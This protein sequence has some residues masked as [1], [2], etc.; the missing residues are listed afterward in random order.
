MFRHRKPKPVSAAPAWID[1]ELGP[2]TR[3]V[4]AKY[5]ARLDM[6]ELPP[7]EFWDVFTNGRGTFHVE[8]IGHWADGPRVIAVKTAMMAELSP[9]TIVAMAQSIMNLTGGKR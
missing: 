9:Q 5:A 6:P 7:H 8:L 3:V 2:R 1:G 4:I